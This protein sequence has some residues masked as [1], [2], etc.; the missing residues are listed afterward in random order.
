V[1]L[2]KL[3]AFAMGAICGCGIYSF[4]QKKKKTKQNKLTTRKKEKKK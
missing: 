3:V 1:Y 2:E 4:P